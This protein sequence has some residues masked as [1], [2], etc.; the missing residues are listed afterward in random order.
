MDGMN[1]RTVDLNLLVAL[2]ALIAEQHVT[3]AALRCGLSQPA[4]SSTLRRLRDLFGDELL[5]RTTAGMEP[6]PRARHLIG[7]V[8]QVLQ[9]IT[10]IIEAE[11]SF[12]PLDSARTFSMRMGDL[13]D[14]LIMPHIVARLEREAP[15]IALRVAHLPPD[16]TVAALEA[17]EIDF[18]I[19]TGLDHPKTI[20]SVPLYRDRIVCVFRKGHPHARLP[21][22]LENF[23]ALR[24][25]KI[26]QS[27]TDTRFVDDAIT[28]LGRTRNVVLNVQHW[29]GAPEIVRGT[30]LVSVMWERM[31]SRMSQNDS[32]VLGELPFALKPFHF[33]LYW[34][35]R[36]DGDAAHAWMRQLVLD[37]GR[38][39][40]AA[41][42][43][44]DKVFH[45]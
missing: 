36:H 29:L 26:A 1:L 15:G 41:A 40:I 28:R 9:D 27:P 10:R 6:T 45:I 31:A 20:R 8:R 35:R 5:V 44:V 4:M 25:I 2:D 19:S 23:L 39:D 37:V 12:A 43:A 18:G 32:L 33:C 42:R 14:V 34:H 3:R 13:H 7:P 11:R 30:D 17:G 38:L 22:T 24:H 16:Q 21:M